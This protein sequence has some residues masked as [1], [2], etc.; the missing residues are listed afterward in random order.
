MLKCSTSLW[1]ADLANLAAA[2]KRVEPHSERF[3]LDVADG[4]YSP[5]LLFFPDLVAALRPHTGL[6]FEIHLMTTDPAAW[7][8]PFADAGADAIIICFD[9]TDDP[10]AVLA[11][12]KA[13]GLQTGVSLLLEEEIDLLDPHWEQLDILTLLQTPAGIKGAD[14]DER[15]PGRIRRSRAEIEQR[16][17]ATVVEAD[18]GIRRHTVPKIAAAG[19]DFIVPGSLMFGEDPLAMRRW[20]AGLG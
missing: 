6:P 8:D 10:G 2:I 19:A 11:A 18:G 7:I 15:A 17:L 16:G 9:S 3:H 1:S 14:M 13:R 4:H 12:I 5:T 20:L